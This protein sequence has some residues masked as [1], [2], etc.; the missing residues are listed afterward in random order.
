MAWWYGNEIVFSGDLARVGIASITYPDLF[1][2]PAQFRTVPA[3]V[4]LPGDAEYLVKAC[5]DLTGKECQSRAKQAW[6]AIANLDIV[7]AFAQ[8]PYRVGFYRHNRGILSEESLSTW[9][10]FLY[11]GRSSAS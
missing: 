8:R 7:A 3:P 2:V 6:D 1:L 11:A 9:V 4:P 5:Q 10:I